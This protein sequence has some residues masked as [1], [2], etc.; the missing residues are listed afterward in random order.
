MVRAPL[1][2]EAD[3]VVVGGGVMGLST[4]CHLAEAGVER[5]VVLERGDLG[6]GS[7]VKAAGGVRAVFSDEINIAL[8]LRSLEALERFGAERGQDID[9]HQVGYLFLLDDADDVAAFTRDAA[10]QVASGVDSRMIDAEEA[11]RLS[12]LVRPDGLLGALFSPSGGHCTPEAVVQGYARAARRAGATVVTGCAAGGLVMDGEEVLAVRTAAGDVATGTVV[13]AAGAW[14]REVGRWAGVELPVVPLRRHVAITEAVPGLD[15]ATPFTIDFTS[16]FYF[17]GEGPG[18]L[19]GLPDRADVWDFGQSRDPRW[20]E[21]LAGAIEHRAPALADVGI[22][23][24]WAGLYEMTPDH[25]AIIGRSTQVPGLVYACGFSGHGFLMG[26][27]VGEVV[28][29]LVLG[30]PPVVDVT[31][32]SVDRFAAASSRPERNIV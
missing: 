7:T 14:S 9:L 11:V 2:R 30:H 22:A 13:C 25:N 12:P 16:S 28:R 1:P 26:P 8:G 4:A 17:H 23:T 20:L 21:D 18:L 29:D 31:A 5:V 3:V 10:L 15:P 6:G 32:L 19:M 24:G 27:A